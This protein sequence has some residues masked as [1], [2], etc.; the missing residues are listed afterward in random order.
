MRRL[1]VIITALMLFSPARSTSQVTPPLKPDS[2]RMAVIGD[3]GTGETRQYDVARR[4]ME[5]HAT[6]PF[7]F[8][9]MLGDNIYGG[10]TPKDFERK[11]S[12]PY[13][14]LLDAGVKFYASLGNHDNANERFYAP[15]NMNGSAYY[16]FKKGNVRFFALDSNYMDPKQLAWLENELK[17]AG[18]GN[19]KICYF[20]HP[21]YSSGKTHG[22]STD[23]R[24]LLEPLF[25]RYYVNVVFAG[26]DH[27]YERV[28]PQDGIYYFTEGSSGELRAG[29]LNR[30]A[31]TAKGYDSDNTFMV[32]EFAGDQM[33]FQTIS[34]TGQ[35][36]DSGTIVRQAQT[37]SATVASPKCAVSVSAKTPSSSVRGSLASLRHPESCLPTVKPNPAPGLL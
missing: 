19:W 9:V 13:K 35:T 24:K 5:A 17:G 22:S 37:S 36:V 34:R 33:N 31:I 3:M 15:Y 2:I 16:S 8:V 18:D 4:M 32:V 11:F 12:V 14:P 21:L 28:K 27:V 25:R 20:H 23:L 10:S 7:D 29:D 30:S 1:I 6:F 26:H